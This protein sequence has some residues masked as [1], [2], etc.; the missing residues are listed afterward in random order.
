M[1]GSSSLRRRAQEAAS[2]RTRDLPNPPLSRSA[3]R[4]VAD[5]PAISVGGRAGAVFFRTLP[6]PASTATGQCFCWPAEI[7]APSPAHHLSTAT[8]LPLIP[9]CRD[10]RY[11]ASRPAA[12][13]P[14]IP[15][16]ARR[17]KI[18][19]ATAHPVSAF[20][21]SHSTPARRSSRAGIHSRQHPSH[22]PKP[23]PSYSC[24]RPR[25][26]VSVFLARAPSLLSHPP[27]TSSNRPAAPVSASTL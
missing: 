26:V 12:A 18:V 7:P 2:V 21:K 27:S 3:P 8:L 23:S 20:H 16:A 10:V 1:C 11:A 13:P 25:R 14:N 24:S 19:H 15:P 9:R 4:Q 6:L 22:S 5:F 17:G